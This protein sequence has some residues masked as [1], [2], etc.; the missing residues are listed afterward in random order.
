[1]RLALLVTLPLLALTAC[2]SGAAA[3]I[4]TA[5]SAVKAA[6]EVTAGDATCGVARTELVSGVNTFT[7][8]NAGSDVTEV[9]VYGPKDAI[10]GEVENIG[11]GLS[12]TLTVELPAGRFE[13][14]CKPGLKGAG[15]RTPIT[16]TAAGSVAPADPR[17]ATGVAD[18]TAWVHTEVATM[19][20]ATRAFTEAVEAGDVVRAKSLYAASRIPWERIEP[21][22]ESFGDL[23]PRIDA[24]EA[25]LQPGQVW[26]GWH[27]LEKS[28]WVKGSVAGDAPVARQ[29]MVD[30]TALAAKV[31]TVVLTPSQLGNGAKEL[32]D[33]V[34]TGKITGEEEAFSH[35]DLVDFAANVEGAKR[36]YDALRPVA[37]SREPKLVAELDAEFTDVAAALAPYGN[38]ASFRSYTDLTKDQVRRL[39]EA[40]DALAEP[41]SRLTAAVVA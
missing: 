23:D 21:V 33:E 35:T 14:A 11:P 31:Q 39:A 1:M 8:R 13:V 41:L 6:V 19:L 32:L 36:A 3:P 9:Y 40:V 25:D 27:R 24:R 28:L 15:I 7:V 22:A 5:G 18:Y 38:G 16:V 30:L 37:L 10:A 4:P 17:L 12:R 26:T 20:T 34:A 29:L 2:G